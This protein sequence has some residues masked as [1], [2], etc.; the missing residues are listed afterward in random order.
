VY[1][2]L[3]ANILLSKK[4]NFH[5]RLKKILPARAGGMKISISDKY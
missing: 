1:K 3:F 2:D 5:R 4:E